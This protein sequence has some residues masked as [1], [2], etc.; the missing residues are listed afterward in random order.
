MPSTRE[1]IL[2]A[3]K[4]ALDTISGPTVL[5]N[6]AV[7]E[8]IPEA[9]LVVLRDGDPGE[10]EILLSPLT[11]AFDHRAEI[12]V[13]VENGIDAERD[14]LFDG[15]MQSISAAVTADR[16]FG[17]LCDWSEPLPP[18]PLELPV[19]GADAMKAVSI[20]L[21]LNYDAPDGLA[22]PDP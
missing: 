5:R 18:E 3:V 21:V 14:A 4:A 15:L 20:Q 8:R 19:E 16:T 1:T 11:Y 12:E 6:A 22:D 9:G 17:G 13:I 2:L 10:P 7:P